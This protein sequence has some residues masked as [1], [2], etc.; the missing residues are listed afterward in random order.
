M[1]LTERG[2]ARL[3]LKLTPDHLLDGPI[4]RYLDRASTR[5]EGAVKRRAPVDKGRMRNSAT[6]EV[7]S[8]TP[9]RWAKVGIT[10]THRGVNYGAVL[11]AGEDKRGRVYHY[12]GGGAMGLSGRPTKGWMTEGAVGDAEADLARYADDLGRDIRRIWER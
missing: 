4:R 1:R 8:R 6:R 9:P 12:R 2:L 10:A 3:L 11:D 7:D 5:L